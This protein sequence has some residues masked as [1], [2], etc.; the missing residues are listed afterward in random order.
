MR[1]KKLRMQMIE[2]LF[3]HGPLTSGEIL[4]LLPKNRYTPST[5]EIGAFLTHTKEVEL[6]NNKWRIKKCYGQKNTGHKV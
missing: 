2:V 4:T 1:R 3:E 6:V 5:T